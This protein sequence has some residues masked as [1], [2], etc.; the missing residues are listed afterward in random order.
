M[1]RSLGELRF[2]VEKRRRLAFWQGER[3]EADLSFGEGV[4]LSFHW[5]RL[6]WDLR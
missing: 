6:G 1:K 2:A 5:L 4:Q 3:V